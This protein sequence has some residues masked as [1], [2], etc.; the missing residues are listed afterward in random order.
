MLAPYI[1]PEK[2]LKHL[3]A[4]VVHYHAYPNEAPGVVA[5]TKRLRERFLDPERIRTISDDELVRVARLG[6]TYEGKWESAW[7]A[8][9]QLQS[10]LEL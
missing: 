1:D 8:T 2:F 6:D 5:Y 7:L 3:D 10:F 9:Y 4:I